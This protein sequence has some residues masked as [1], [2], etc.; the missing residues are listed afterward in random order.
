[1]YKRRPAELISIR[2]RQV[3]WSIF[4]TLRFWWNGISNNTLH[5]K[6]LVLIPWVGRCWLC[7]GDHQWRAFHIICWYSEHHSVVQRADSTVQVSDTGTHRDRVFLPH[8]L[9]W[10]T[11]MRVSLEAVRNENQIK[12]Q[13]PYCVF[14]CEMPFAKCGRIG[15][16]QMMLCF[17]TGSW[18]AHW[19][20]TEETSSTRF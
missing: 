16:L 1:M 15:A 12:V 10:A 5:N 20:E 8:I 6:R 2:R 19:I 14:E 18:N 4:K 11:S 17:C 3:S 13:T 9:A 7:S